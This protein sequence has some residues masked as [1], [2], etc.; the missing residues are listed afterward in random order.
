MCSWKNA[1]FTG[2]RSQ[3]FSTTAIGTLTFFKD[4]ATDVPAVDF[5]EVDRDTLKIFISSDVNTTGTL[6]IPLQG[7]SQNFN[8]V[9][10]MTTTLI[11][12]NTMAESI[13]VGSETVDTKGILIETN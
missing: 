7:Y 9:A 4:Q 6:S 1:G 5:T 2:D 10:N 8:V 11:V 3:I 13:D 12:D